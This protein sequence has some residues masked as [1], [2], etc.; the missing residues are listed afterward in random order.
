MTKF[1]LAI[2]ACAFTLLIVLAGVNIWHGLHPAPRATVS[3]TDPSIRIGGPFSLTD[4]DGKPVTQE[5][6]KG[7][8]SAVFFGY[9]FCP[10]V[11]PLTLQN[12]AHTQ[13]LLGDKARNLQ[14]IFITVDPAR[15]TPANLKAYLDSNGFPKNVIGLTGSQDAIDKVEKEYR[16]TATKTGSGDSYGYSHTAVVYLMNPQGQFD[17]P[18]TASM[19]PQQNAQQ[20]EQA[21]QGG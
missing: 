4:Q 6:L 14:I 13:A 17:V 18:L 7:K 3:Q 1:R 15:D 19:T 20:I 10:D 16:A 8:W 5:I 12:L 9:T 11:C 2:I 21:M